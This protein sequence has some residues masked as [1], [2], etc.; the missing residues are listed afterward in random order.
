MA[1]G[2]PV[3]CRVLRQRQLE[4]GRGLGERDG[5]AR[6]GGQ[7]EV[8]QNFLGGASAG[9]EGGHRALAATGTQPDVNAPGAGVERGLC[10]FELI[11][12]S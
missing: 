2:S 4:L 8:V 1:R 5:A 3:K 10:R 6:Q 12:A 11:A 9:D 7:A